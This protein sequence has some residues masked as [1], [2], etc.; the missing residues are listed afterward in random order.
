[1]LIGSSLVTTLLIP[2]E[3]IAEGRAR[4]RDARSAYLAH[5]HLG[6]MFG[7]IYDIST[8]AILW[9]AGASAMA[10]LLNLVPRYL[11]RYGMAPEW[12]QGDAAAGRCCSPAI[13][14]LITIIFNA[15]V[16][17]QGGAY[18][19]G[20]LVL[21]TSAA[22]RGD[23]AACAA[24]AA[25]G[26][27]SRRSRWCS[28]TRPSP[29][30]SS[31]PTACKIAAWFIATIIVTSLISR[32]L[33]STELRVQGVETDDRR[34]ALHPGGRR[35]RRCGSSPT[36]PTP[37]LPEEYQHKLREAR[38]SHHLPETTPVL[39]LEVRPGDASEFSGVLKVARRR[40]RRVPR[41]ALREPGDS[42]TP[43]R[44]CCCTSAT[45]PARSRTPISAGRK[46]TR[47]PTC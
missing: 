20:V 30:S 31:G 4:H 43:S 40:R 36:V 24:A 21:M 18:A 14:F 37:G 16:D 34:A 27:R 8:I 17:A 10:G 38:E 13:T 35:P 2:A 3:A 33:R 45:R 44:R 46:A 6:E 29:T 1:M 42:R 7:T 22:R 26:W 15:D 5:E 32:V 28:S 23:A 39:F 19:T 47:S 11:P 9:F 12:T 41:A 25:A